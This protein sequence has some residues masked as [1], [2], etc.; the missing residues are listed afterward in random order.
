MLPE[1]GRGEKS[2]ISKI[3]ETSTVSTSQQEHY[4]LQDSR[5]VPPNSEG[6]LF[7]DQNSISAKLSIN[8]ERI[9]K[10]FR[11]A[12][13]L[14]L[15]KLL[16]NVL[17]KRERVTKTEDD[18]GHKKQKMQ[19]ERDKEKCSRETQGHSSIL[20]KEGQPVQIGTGKSLRGKWKK[21]LQEVE[22]D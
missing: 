17:H 12:V 6:K 13:S 7:C 9:I 8:Y 22:I 3:E 16:E 15:R 20:N 5:E 4:K 14:F 1:N 19:R 21:H 11:N 18:L 10:H 2:V